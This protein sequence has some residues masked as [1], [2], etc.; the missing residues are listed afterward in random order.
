MQS[1]GCDD[2]MQFG[3]LWVAFSLWLKAPEGARDCTRLP[4]PA[5]SRALRFEAGLSA[6]HLQHVGVC[7]C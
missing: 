4:E 6:V 1:L 2:F 5:D 3:A 7:N